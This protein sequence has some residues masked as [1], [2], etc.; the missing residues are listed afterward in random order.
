MFSVLW[1]CLF[2]ACMIDSAF[3]LFVRIKHGAVRMNGSAFDNVANAMVTFAE[4]VSI[5]ACF[6]CLKILL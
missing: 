6:E 1:I 2:S 4:F 3:I 5:I